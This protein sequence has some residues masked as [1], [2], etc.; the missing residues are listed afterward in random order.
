MYLWLW[1]DDRKCVYGCDWMIGNVSMVVIGWWEMSSWLWL[2]DRWMSDRPFYWEVW[3]AERRRRHHQTQPIQTASIIHN[4]TGVI[5]IHIYKFILGPAT[6]N[7]WIYSRIVSWIKFKSFKK[8]DP[9]ILRFECYQ[10]PKIMTGVLPKELIGLSGRPK[11]SSQED[12]ALPSLFISLPTSAIAGQ[13]LLWRLQYNSAMANQHIRSRI[14][15][16]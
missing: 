7:S 15:T 3:P 14:I 10:K 9:F 2:D 13:T 8:N 16:Y 4:S 12:S 1:L 6:R 11:G 5:H